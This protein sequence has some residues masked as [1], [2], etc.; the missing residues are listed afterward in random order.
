MLI[1][2]AAIATIN[3]CIVHQV[4]LKTT[5]KKRSGA[6]VSGFF[7]VQVFLPLIG[8]S[9]EIDAAFKM[10]RK[11]DVPTENIHM[12]ASSCLLKLV[13]YMSRAT[14]RLFCTTFSHIT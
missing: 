3:G 14:T 9:P 6:L 10:C 4:W 1:N 7:R 12:N 5:V 11:N 13:I 8:Y 2:F